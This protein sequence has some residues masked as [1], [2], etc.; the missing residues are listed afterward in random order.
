MSWNT[1]KPSES[2]SYLVSIIKQLNGQHVFTYTAYYDADLDIWFKTDPF[3]LIKKHT[4]EQ[5]TDKVSAWNDDEG[6]PVF[7]S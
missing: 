5:I 3:D 1:S 2:G 4:G 6:I 7:I